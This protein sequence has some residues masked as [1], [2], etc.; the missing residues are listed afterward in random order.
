MTTMKLIDREYWMKQAD[1]LTKA[2]TATADIF[3]DREGPLVSERCLLSGAVTDRFK[4]IT[5]NSDLLTW[6]ILAAAT[7]IALRR[8]GGVS[9]VVLHINTEQGHRLP[10]LLTIPPAVTFREW[11]GNVRRVTA[12]AIEHGSVDKALLTQFLGHLR[13][14]VINGE[15]PEMGIAIELDNGVISVSGT[16]AA[17]QTLN[18]LATGIAAL[19]SKGLF[20]LDIRLNNMT[21]VDEAMQTKLLTEFNL[22]PDYGSGKSF[23]QLVVEQV[24]SNPSA[25]ALRDETESLTYWELFQLASSV[26]L[27]LKKAGISADDIVALSAPRSVRYIAVAT[28]IL[29]SG[30]AYLPI[31]PTLPQARQMHM[32]KHAKALIAD[33]VV[34][35]SQIILFSFSELSFQNSVLAEDINLFKQQLIEPLPSEL[36]YV[37]FT[38]GSTGLPKGVGIEHRSFLNLLTFRVQNCELK[39]G[40]TLPQTAPIS[41]D[42]SVW[43]MFTGLTAGA[44]VSIV[45]D[46]VVK[47]PQV[48]IQYIIE[49]QFEYIELVPSL[50]AV[51]LD[52]LEQS[53]SLKMRVQQQLRGMISTGEVLSTELAR[54]WHQCMPMVA[55]LNAYGPAECT[56]DVTQGKV[57]E[58][59]DGLYC[60]VGAPLPNVTIYVLDKD[61]Q[62]VPPMVGGEIFIGGPNVGR[63]YIGSNRLTAAAFLPD[64]FISIPGARMYR[65][66]D[67]GRWR[68]EGVLEC[69]GRADNQVKIRGRRVELGEIEAVLASH[70]DIAMCAVELVDMGGFEQLSAFV[71]KLNDA[72]ADAKSLSA[73]LSKQLPDYMVPSKFYFL[74]ALLCNANGKV[75]RNQLKALA[76]QQPESTSYVAPQTKLEQQLCDLWCKYL[77]LEKVSITEDFFALGGDSII[78]IRLMHEVGSLGI[79]LRPRHLLEYPTIASLAKLANAKGEMVVNS[80]LQIERAPLTPIQ[81]WF[82]DQQFSEQHHWNQ[83]HVISAKE[84][85]DAE[86]LS[87]AIKMLVEHHDQL[88]VCFPREGE[89]HYQ[90][91]NAIHDDLLWMAEAD[92]SDETIANRAHASLSIEKG[93]LLRV[94]MLDDFRILLTLHHLIVDQV[95]WQILLEDLE[96]A[97]QSIIQKVTPRLPRKSTQYLY[98][99]QQQ[100]AIPPQIL[101]PLR[102]TT[103][104]DVVQVNSNIGN[105]Y[106]NRSVV[107]VNLSESET[108]Y[109]QEIAALVPNG[110]MP[111]VLLTGLA[112]SIAAAQGC[113]QLLI[114]LEGHGRQEENESIDVMRTVGWFTTI[115]P[116][117]LPI[118]STVTVLEVTTAM[119][120]ASPYIKAHLQ[121]FYVMPENL[122]IGFNYLGRFNT[123]Q[124]SDGFFSIE[125]DIGMRRAAIS[126]RP[127]EWEINA[128]IVD[129][130]LVITLEYVPFRHNETAINTLLAKWRS[131]LTKVKHAP[132]GLSDL[133]PLAPAQ[134]AF[135]ERD[136]PNENYCNHGV[137][138]TLSRPLSLATIEHSASVLLERFPILG[139]SFVAT[140]L[141]RWQGINPQARIAVEQFE[142]Q[143]LSP[144]S[145][146][147]KIT[148]LAN[149]GHESLD[150]LNGPICR[151]QFYQTA[152]NLPDKLLII[153]HHL[154][155]DPYSWDLITE[156]LAALLEGT[157]LHKLKDPTTSYFAWARRLHRLV[158]DD[159]E[160]FGIHYWL[161]QPYE[162]AQQLVNTNA[163][164]IE[165][166]MVEQITIL[167]EVQTRQFLRPSEHSQLPVLARLLTLL[168]RS[169]ERHFP[170]SANNILIELGG[171][172]RE[173]LFDDVD[174]GRTVGWFTCG[175]PFLLPFSM[176]RNFAEHVTEVAQLL[177]EVPSRGFGFEVLRYLSANS[178]IAEKLKAIPRPQLRLDFEGELLFLNTHDESVTNPLFIDITTDGTGYWKPLST[179]MD[180][181][182][183]FNISVN[184]GVMEIRAQFAADVVPTAQIKTVLAEF[185]EQITQNNQYEN[186]NEYARDELP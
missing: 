78:G 55:L 124:Q 175:F 184:D 119:I 3:S 131:A 52:I 112:N 67:R 63:G 7:S 27:R 109:I 90:A 84:Q 150:L 80:T 8:I 118:N 15:R 161:S 48:L 83:S 71:T 40:A 144:D 101:P 99:S 151:I 20:D 162:Q 75:D 158:Q 79:N 122:K 50:I 93:P 176:G 87:L 4:R 28:G 94:V 60:P 177:D 105:F 113:G 34:D 129:G 157:E 32:L 120:E 69:F 172:G 139:A 49:Q 68:N 138:L 25:I 135:F 58:Q 145:L 56:D 115:A 181:L 46:D 108:Q 41:F 86:T 30:G 89:Q 182:L 142:L 95:S 163:I 44:T 164:G 165:A 35:M 51:I 72:A 92:C 2:A 31:D 61:F 166:N 173:D 169:L 137:L 179:P 17:A 9:S 19:L 146:S 133:A 178:Q 22:P 130:K 154:V 23:Y 70:P 29:F 39:L 167:N 114:E 21:I 82:F 81:Q 152:H 45:S 5:G 127:L 159:P 171:H 156:D 37:I 134:H 18:Q 125:E 160:R 140:E 88:R 14:I 103:P 174:L 66:G 64:P 73:F 11:L 10:V 149:L 121:Q 110:G 36:A 111:A 126:Q 76:K 96:M 26:A 100:A 170:S 136:N 13:P 148:E 98:W 74:D 24:E 1:D 77:K 47:D 65:T 183:S 57:G 186:T 180:Y 153:V 168:A 38:S 123:K 62:L 147:Q 107:E 104:I 33:H 141:G 117:V 16:S 102:P 132:N 85:L 185:N 42:I 116:F 91:L 143:Q 53:V 43:Q 155:V 59:F 97:Y 54:R 128:A 12:A 106:G 6:S